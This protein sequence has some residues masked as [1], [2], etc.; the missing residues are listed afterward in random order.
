[1]IAV[2]DEQEIKDIKA[3]LQ[4]LEKQ[5]EH[6]TAVPIRKRSGWVSFGIAFVIVFVV[7]VIGFGVIQFIND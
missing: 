4:R 3:A 6:L 1:M 7:M 2:A 5:I